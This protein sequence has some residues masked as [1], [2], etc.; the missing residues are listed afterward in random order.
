MPSSARKAAVP[1]RSCFRSARK[2]LLVLQFPGR[3]PHRGPGVP[4]ASAGF[5]AASAASRMAAAMGWL[6]PASPGP[7]GKKVLGRSSRGGRA[8][9]P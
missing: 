4:V 2:S 1:R 7:Q 3:T 8:P 6:E 9:V 5:R